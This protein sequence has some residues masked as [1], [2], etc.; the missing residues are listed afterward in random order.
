M[1]LII[2]GLFLLVA[3]LM[4]YKMGKGDKFEINFKRFLPQLRTEEQEQ[5][6]IEKL[7]QNKK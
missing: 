5:Q 1:E 3:V 4:G 2:F 7:R 6:L